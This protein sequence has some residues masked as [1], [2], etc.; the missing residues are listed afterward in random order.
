PDTEARDIDPADA[1]A[2]ISAAIETGAMT[3]PPFETDTWPACRPLVEWAAAMLPLGGTGYPRPRWDAEAVAAL[4]PPFPAPPV[5]AR[6]RRPGPRGAAGP[7][8]VV[9][10][11]LRPGCPDALKPDGGGDPAARLAAPQDRR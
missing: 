8:A 2:R 10:H 3:F 7:A 9:R 5:G 4:A 1:R 6:A 11:R